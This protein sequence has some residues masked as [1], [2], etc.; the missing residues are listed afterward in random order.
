MKITRII[1]SAV[2]AAILI[3]AAAFAKDDIL[4]G[5]SQAGSKPKS[6]SLFKDKTNA[7]A[8]HNTVKY[9]SIENVT[10]GFGT[11]MQM[12]KAK[13]YRGKRIK[14]SG[15][16]K[17]E[18]VTGSAGLWMRVDGQGD[19]VLAFDNMRDRAI[20]GTTPWKKCEVVLDVAQMESSAIGFGVRLSGNG[21]IW[22][23]GLNL[24][25]VDKSVPCTGI[26]ANDPASLP[27]KPTNMDLN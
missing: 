12:M 3:S 9:Q 27:D 7:H 16:I 23:S 14:L 26:P 6:Y 17:S 18:N 15:Y 4:N 11:M 8:G 5:W 22:V 13:Q 25:V 24:S 21:T 1:V 20:T 10:D 2:F 19:T